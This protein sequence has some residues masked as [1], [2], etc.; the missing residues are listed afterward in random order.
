MLLRPV[1]EARAPK[2]PG[3]TSCFG[4]SA[5]QGGRGLVFF[6]MAGPPGPRAARPEDKPCAGHLARERHRANDAI[7]FAMSRIYLPRG[8][9]AL[10][11]RVRT[12]HGEA[13]EV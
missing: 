2:G 10:G 12:G 3:T 4:T 8:R 5:P 7:V 13:R 1:Q 9:A 6:T 11:G